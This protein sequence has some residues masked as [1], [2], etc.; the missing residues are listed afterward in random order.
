MGRGLSH[1][2]R[3][4]L[5]A[6]RELWP[7]PYVLSYV[8]SRPP[9]PLWDILPP[10]SHDAPESWSWR[11]SIQGLERS[12]HAFRILTT[13]PRRTSARQ[14]VRGR[15]EVQGLVLTKAG[16]MHAVYNEYFQPDAEDEALRARLRLWLAAH[17]AKQRR[18]E[19]PE[20]YP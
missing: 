9:V 12:G 1:R 11:R 7:G 10:G 13:R 17:E 15:W 16:W 6:M 5:Q 4:I 3:G 14:K 19:Y 20:G 8:L 2:Q 18:E